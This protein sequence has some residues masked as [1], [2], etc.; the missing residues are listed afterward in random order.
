MRCFRVSHANQYHQRFHCP[1]RSLPLQMIL[2]DGLAADR[3]RVARLMPVRQR[4][5]PLE[6]I[7]VYSS[8]DATQ[9]Q[10][11]QQEVHSRQNEKR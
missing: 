11:H 1:F 2:E 5:Q 7:T 9:K 4:C 6:Y 8:C 10:N 3:V